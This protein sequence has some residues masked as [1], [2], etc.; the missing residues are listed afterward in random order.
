MPISIHIINISERFKPVDL[1]LNL[2]NCKSCSRGTNEIS[3]FKCRKRNRCRTSISSGRNAFAFPVHACTSIV[4]FACERWRHKPRKTRIRT[5]KI[6][7]D[8]KPAMTDV[9]VYNYMNFFW[10]VNKLINFYLSIFIKNH[11]FF[12]YIV[13]IYNMYLIILI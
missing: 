3:E 1:S 2:I 12:I 11:L 9:D 6:Y 13:F 4:I 7:S 5:R 8:V 10:N